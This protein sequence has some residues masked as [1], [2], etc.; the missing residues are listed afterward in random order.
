MK[1]RSFIKRLQHLLVFYLLGGEKL[2]KILGVKIGSNCRVYIKSFGSEPFLISI[3]NNVTLTLGVTFITHDGATCLV[4][5]ESG[6]RYQKFSNIEIGDNVFIC[7]NTIIMPGVKIG[8]NVIVAAGSVVS[9][10]LQSNAVYAGVP[11][12]KI[13]SFDAYEKKVKSQYVNNEDLLNESTYEEKVHRAVQ[14]IDQD[15]KGYDK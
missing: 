3:G 12:N 9:K 13:M 10:S 1:I 5:N 15:S 7:V 14:L 8:S 2:A 11:A 6:Q 4:L